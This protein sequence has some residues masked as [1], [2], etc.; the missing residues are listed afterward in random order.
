MSRRPITEELYDSLL[1]AF[2]EAPGNASYAARLSGCDRRM[3][4]R[5]W[6]Q[7]WP[8]FDWAKP[9]RVMLEREKEAARSQRIQAEREIQAKDRGERER[10]RQ[11]AIKT[12]GEEARAVQQLRGNAL[13]L[14]TITSK[15]L[16]AMIPLAERMKVTLESQA[17]TPRECARLIKDL[18]YITRHASEVTKNALEMERLRLGEPTSVLGVRIEEMSPADAVKE[19]SNVQHT[20]ERAR[21]MGWD[22]LPG[23]L[24]EG[25]DEDDGE[26]QRELA[27]NQT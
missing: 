2:R 3:A 14:G 13:G 8:A 5:G 26:F 7:G 4:K 15:M 24:N 25:F 9:I 10:A 20:L 16:L 11:D 27:Q 6:E 1:R 22:V 12:T 18:S 21:A 19:L 17:V 23:G